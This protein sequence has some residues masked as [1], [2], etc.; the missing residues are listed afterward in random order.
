MTV[1]M[2]VTGV[3]ASAFSFS[4]SPLAELGSVLHALVE[5][6]HH[7]EHSGWLS[8]VRA[9]LDPALMDRILDAD[10]LWRTSRADPLLP[11]TPRSTLAEELADWDDIDDDAWVRA[12][13]I[14]S[15][16]GSLAAHPELGS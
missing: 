14:T 3:P 5:P 12:A 13:L 9:G 2:D 8:A 4:P 1:S 7:P 6:D 15:S 16:C 11:A 10:Y